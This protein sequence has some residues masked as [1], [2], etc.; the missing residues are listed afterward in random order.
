VGEGVIQKAGAPPD[1]VLVLLYCPNLRRGVH[2]L[3]LTHERE[4]VDT[5]YVQMYGLREPGKLGFKQRSGFTV[6][7]PPSVFECIWRYSG[8][9]SI[10]LTPFGS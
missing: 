9:R 4:N 10:P 8:C 2:C 5:N 1:D 3:L 7:T 6:Q